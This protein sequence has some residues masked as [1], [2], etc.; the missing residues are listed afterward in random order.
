[1]LALGT[2]R[3]LEDLDR[4]LTI[5][6]DAS[7]TAITARDD[8]VPSRFALLDGE[9]LVR[10]NEDD[11]TPLV[12]LRGAQS[13][14]AAKDGLVIGHEGAHV[15]FVSAAATTATPV[16]SFDTVPGREHWE[17]PGGPSPDTRSV[18]VLGG[19]E[20]F[21]NVHVGGVW[22]SADGGRTWDEVIP[23]EADVH[24][25]VACGDVLAVAAA[26]GFAHSSDGGATWCWSSDGLHAPYCRA[27]ALEGDVAYVSA[28][29]GPRTN[30][31]RLYRGRLGEPFAPCGPGLPASFPFNLD[32]GTLTA[33]GGNVALGT[34]DGRVFRS[35]DGGESF[36]LVAEHKG[37][38][39]VLRYC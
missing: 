34:E 39:T 33:R 3:R 5:A 37:R 29:T 14:A 10:M 11:V 9:R 7:V 12:L 24:E 28:S 20:W 15:S 36:E 38:V 17:N 1:M 35:R 4:E 18:A 2:T 6:D 23:P 31:G 8:R 16:A 25:I 22:R 26:R 30:D 19:T 32:T 21:V 27:V 13:M